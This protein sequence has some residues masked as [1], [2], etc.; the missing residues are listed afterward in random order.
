MNDPLPPH[1]F[2]LDRAE[3][4]RALA[5]GAVS[6]EERERQLRIAA[7]YQALADHT[8]DRAAPTPSFSPRI[9]IPAGLLRQA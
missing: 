6:L 1:L 2:Y 4:L 5:A 3:H 7:M 9:S 8:A